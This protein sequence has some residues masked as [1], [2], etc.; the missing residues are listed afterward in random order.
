M[1]AIDREALI[2]RAAGA[3]MGAFIGDALALGPHWYYDLDELR[4]R[5]GPWISDYTTPMPDHYHA[6]MKAGESSQAG[7]LL[8]LT[9]ES[10][11]DCGGYDEA[12]HSPFFE[13]YDEGKYGTDGGP[14]HDPCAVF[15]VTH[16]ELFDL[17][18]KRVEIE[19]YGEF[20][21]GMTAVD[22]R[23]IVASKKGEPNA[24][25][26][27]EP[28]SAEIFDLIYAAVAADSLRA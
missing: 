23:P 8:R 17:R 24:L 3:L 7:V 25:V 1:T 5:Y 22:E 26:A 19:L 28:K 13:R 27:Y 6:G 21:R 9:L 4:A 16:P 12:D 14:L 11:A 18:A 15:A 2:D 20:T 10:L